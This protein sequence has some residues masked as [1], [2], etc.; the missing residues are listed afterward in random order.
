MNNLEKRP[1]SL[2]SQTIRGLKI[3]TSMTA[4]KTLVD[5]GC[6]LILARLLFPD[7]FGVLAFLISAAG[8][9][10]YIADL[11]GGKYIIQK[12]DLTQ[13]DVDTIF[14][15]ELFVG[16]A[17]ALA[18]LL[19]AGWILHLLK[20]DSLM[21]YAA[22]FSLW[23]ILERFQLAR[24]ILEKRMEFGKSNIAT[25]LGILAGA[26][27][28]VALAL[29][30]CGVHSLIIGLIFR[31]L[32]T[33]LLFWHYSPMQP[34]LKFRADIAAPYLRFGLPLA[35]TS[36][37]V[38]YYWN[39][40]YII[41]GK[42]LNDTQL[43]YYYIAFKFPHYMLQLQSLVSTVVYPAFART[44]DEEQ[45]AR[46]FKLATKYSGALALLPCVAVLALG[47]GI[48]RY[49]LGEKWLPALRPFQIFTCLAAIRM[50]TVHW[51]DVYLSKGK[52]HVMPWL[53]I[54]NALG[55]TLAA[56]AGA[57]YGTLTAVAVGVAA[58]NIAVIL[59]AV[60]VLLK[61][62]LPVSYIQ[63]LWK[64]VL[65]S[66]ATFAVAIIL[67]MTIKDSG[68]F[69]LFSSKMIILFLIYG[70][71]YYIIDRRSLHLLKTRL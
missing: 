62:V 60:N 23:I 48:V 35:V 51:Y 2:L 7:A 34:R 67:N 57:R 49:G 46:G 15:L 8:F 33:A 43:G 29:R 50:I 11:G 19:G 31:S 63:L 66:A 14:T 38:F 47:E 1:S 58:V 65:A 26:L 40:D 25:F 61:K 42:F 32:V 16:I 54:S 39:V 64:P 37:F 55:V 28:S 9:F 24:F 44:K 70:G 52:T 22:P 21:S 12:K 27:I 6:Q 17:L 68:G 71:I 45:L 13:E 36:L 56:W 41:V 20:K 10:C 30:G 18:W 69:I 5:A 59:F 53:S 4:L 3:T